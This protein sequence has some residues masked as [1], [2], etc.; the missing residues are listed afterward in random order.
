MPTGGIYWTRES[1]WTLA[2]ISAILEAAD[3]L[4]RNGAPVV[5]PE[6]LSDVQFYAKVLEQLR[7]LSAAGMKLPF[8]GFTTV[9]N[10]SN[11]ADLLE[12]KYPGIADKFKTQ[13]R[14]EGTFGK[15]LAHRANNGI[16]NDE[17]YRFRLPTL[18]PYFDFGVQVHTSEARVEPPHLF[19]VQES[20]LFAVLEQQGSSPGC[21]CTQHPNMPE[22]IYFGVADDLLARL[23]GH[24]S[25][26]G[27]NR[28]QQVWFTYSEHEAKVLE[29]SVH[30]KIEKS[31]LV[32]SKP[33]PNSKGSYTLKSG[34]DG[35]KLVNAIINE[36]YIYN[37]TR[38]TNGM[39]WL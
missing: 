6:G 11:L 19:Q 34:T 4:L 28:A 1:G 39:I 32:I 16:F 31:G 10:Y 5:V 2:K 33:D 23:S 9:A 27:G 3:H 29:K 14:G 22:Q 8:D 38:T 24:E 12:S 26:Q 18:R 30:L 20:V 37:F 25:R 36:H 21:Y 13:W 15:V 35:L 17:T 7:D